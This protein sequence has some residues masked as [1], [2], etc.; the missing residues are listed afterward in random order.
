LTI[1]REW[2]APQYLS[3]AAA[4]YAIA[5]GILSFVGWYSGT[6]RLTDWWNTGI[7]IKANTTLVVVTSGLA[8]IAILIWPAARLVVR[9][10]A[11]FGS[12]VGA[13]TLFEHVTG[14]DLGIDTLIVDGFLNTATATSNRMGPPV[15][16]SFIAI[17]LALFAQTSHRSRERTFGIGLATA[18]LAIAF[19]SLTGYWYGADAIYVVPRVSGI[20]IQTATMLF[21][22]CIASIAA[23]PDRQPVKT[24]FEDST[25]GVLARRIIPAAIVVPLIL[26]WMRVLGPRANLYDHAF[27]AALRSVFEIAMLGGLS[28]WTVQAVRMRDL[29]QRRADEERH[30]GEQRLRSVIDSSAVPFTVLAP[31]K[32]DS[33]AIIDFAWTYINTAAARTLTKQPESMVGR[34]VTA[35]LPAIWSEPGLFEHYCAVALR[36]ETR[37]FERHLI[38][39]GVEI[40]FQVVASPLD[41]N[42]AIWASDMTERKQQEIAL[43]QLDRRKDEFLATLAH[44]LRNPL[45]PIRQAA[46]LAKKPTISDTQRQWCQDV[47]ERQVQHMA[48][49]LEDLLDVSRITRGI[50][51]LRKKPTTLAAI[52][53]SA[54]ET[55]TPLIESKRHTLK[56]D[57]PAE[58]IQLDVD[59][60][61]ISQVI[62]N[63]LNNAAKY[64]NAGGSIQIAGKVLQADLVLSVTDSGIGI[65]PDELASIFVM[66]SQVK[67]AQERSEG[68]LGIGLSLTKGLIEL[69]GGTIE[70]QSAGPG[71]GSA[72]IITLPNACVS[73]GQ[74]SARPTVPSH[75]ILHKRILLADDNRDA[76]VSLAMLLRSDGHDVKLVHDGDEAVTA[77]DAFNPDIVLLDIGMPRRSGYEVAK[78][79]R[80]TSRSALLI[81]ITGWGQSS[82][83]EKSTAAGF[84]YHLTKPV[85]YDSLTTLLAS[86]ED[87]MGIFS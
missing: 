3:L 5:G 16:A 9:S 46:L 52:V 51:E 10:L 77:F 62:S 86:R 54:V 23:Q 79:I 87:K 66:F 67:S 38:T 57:I 14:Y 31:V 48:L 41:D 20:P 68:G 63:L 43:R 74:H 2:N 45:A 59:P 34:R 40:W 39:D 13:L 28:W 70:A 22:L 4:T 58:L 33:G 18:V 21:A 73:L 42:V 47:I 50:L 49:L 83:R 84:D 85:D 8:V 75:P 55:A 15:A 29:H 64:T 56:I 80:G 72:F 7:T 32:D 81:A 60:L 44:E 24:I 1:S 11:V 53:E 76:A 71:L 36:R 69:H 82:D 17:G 35:I 61:R 19:L 26:G 78:Y 30:A 25:A 27:G 6:E 65:P 12:A 37:E